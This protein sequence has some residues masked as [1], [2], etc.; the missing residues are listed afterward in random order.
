MVIPVPRGGVRGLQ[1]FPPGQ[2][3]TTSSLSL[4]RISERNVE[5]IVDSPC[6]VETFK[7]FAQYR[8][9][10]LRPLLRTFQLVPWTS[11]FTVFAGGSAVSQESTGSIQGFRGEAA[12]HGPR[13]KRGTGE[14][15]FFL[16]HP[17]HRDHGS[18]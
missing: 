10:R 7:I 3:S 2:A 8:V 17:L 15:V 16:V 1:G 13:G 5:Q 9:Q 6:L 11:R 18:F 14:C 12:L 4:E